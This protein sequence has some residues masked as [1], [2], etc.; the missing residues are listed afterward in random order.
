M[1]LLQCSLVC[2]LHFMKI[3][4]F[5]LTGTVLV[6]VKRLNYKHS[7]ENKRYKAILINSYS[8]YN[9]PFITIPAISGPTH[10]E[11]YKFSQHVSRFL[12]KV[13]RCRSYFSAPSKIFK[14]ITYEG[15][16][17]FMHAKAGRYFNMFTFY[18]IHVSS[19]KSF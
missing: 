3:N 2:H 9:L 4:K 19:T 7:F 18:C 6:T 5:L 15:C 13:F 16:V 12:L 14:F 11:G 10:E 8:K 17:L 1:R